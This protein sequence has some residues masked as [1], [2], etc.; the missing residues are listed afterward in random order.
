MISLIRDSI[1][2][3]KGRQHLFQLLTVVK[4]LFIDS[5]VSLSKQIVTIS[6]HIFVEGFAKINTLFKEKDQISACKINSLLLQV[7]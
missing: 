1:P 2:V 7:K 3:S 4:M 6:E 5:S